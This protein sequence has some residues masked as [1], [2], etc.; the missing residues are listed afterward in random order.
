MYV[1]SP[2]STLEGRKIS[3]IYLSGAT[4][5]DDFASKDYHP[6]GLRMVVLARC[7]KPFLPPYLSPLSLSEIP[8]QFYSP[9]S[10]K[11]RNYAINKRVRFFCSMGSSQASINGNNGNNNW[12][13]SSNNQQLEGA[14]KKDL[15]VYNTM[16]RKKEIF[17]PKVDGKVGMYVC[18]VTAYDFSHIGHARAY[19]TFDIL[20]RSKV[21]PFSFSLYKF[22]ML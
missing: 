14:I 11:I 18:G 13:G 5:V 10:N 22:L 20:Y 16:S 6:R 8:L 15:W 17:K 9:F 1:P 3:H 19:V 21:H 4:Q 7:C 2:D 12:V